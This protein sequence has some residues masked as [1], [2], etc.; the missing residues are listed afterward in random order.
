M[1]STRYRCSETVVACWQ[2]DYLQSTT[3]NADTNAYAEDFALWE[4][5]LALSP[6]VALV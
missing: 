5:E 3:I 2:G 4:A 1:G 6:E